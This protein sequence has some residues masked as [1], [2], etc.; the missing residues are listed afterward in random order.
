M[1][2]KEW[3]A[4]F[5]AT[6][7]RPAYAHT[8]VHQERLKGLT[9]W[10]A[11]HLIDVLPTLLHM[12]LLLFSL[13]PAV[14]LWT[15]DKGVA[16][17]EVIITGSTVIFYVGTTFLGA[18]YPSCPLVT[19]ISRYVQSFFDTIKRRID[20]NKSPDDIEKPSTIQYG[21]DNKLQALLWLAENAR[22]PLAGD[23]VRQALIGL[24]L[25]EFYEKSTE[26]VDTE[27]IK[28]AGNIIKISDLTVE[29]QMS[30]TN[31]IINLKRH[32]M[33]E[34]LYVAVL[35]RISEGRLRIPQE[36]DGYRGMELAQYANALPKMAYI[37]ES[38]SQSMRGAKG[39]GDAKIEKKPAPAMELAFGA[40]DSIWSEVDLKLS[41]DSYAAFP[42]AELQLIVSATLIHCSKSSSAT[43]ALGSTTQ[44][45]SRFGDQQNNASLAVP[46]STSGA[47]TL[48]DMELNAQNALNIPDNLLQIGARYSR[49]MS[50]VGYILSCHNKYGMHITTRALIGLLESIKSAAE[51]LE[52]N[53]QDQMSTCLPQPDMLHTLPNFTMVIT[54]HVAYEIHGVE[55]LAIGDEDGLL[56]GL[57]EI[58]SAAD[59]QDAPDFEF[60]AKR[61]LAIMGPVLLRQWATMMNA[62]SPDEF[63]SYMSEPGSIEQAHKCWSLLRDNRRDRTAHSRLLQLLIIATISVELASC[64][65]MIVLPNIAMVSLYRRAKTISGEAAWLDLAENPYFGYLISR[66][67]LNADRNYDKL[68]TEPLQL[69]TKLLLIEYKGK[70]MLDTDCLSPV[71]IPSMPRLTVFLPKDQREVLPVLDELQKM[72][73]LGKYLAPFTETSDGLDALCRVI[74][75]FDLAASPYAIRCIDCI[76]TMPTVYPTYSP[77]RLGFKGAATPGLLRAVRLIFPA[78]I[79]GKN[80]P[81]SRFEVVVRRVAN[82][83]MSSEGSNFVVEG[84]LDDS[85]TIYNALAPLTDWREYSSDTVFAYGRLAD[86]NTILYW[87]CG[88]YLMKR[89]LVK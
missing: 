16:I 69:F 76:I 7:L 37:L 54:P 20:T 3:L 44:D 51:R 2:A 79:A 55:P 64:P 13:G 34:N 84:C 85:T 12:S 25:D 74:D 40:L 89:T 78:L 57:V 77:N 60:A 71:S 73:S 18:V 61:A 68:S 39:S 9:R 10:C 11:L 32:R 30:E 31:R 59:I 6:R 80:S 22:N 67:A 36:P 46:T 26:P 83:L 5:K 8:V 35:A 1:L 14:Y 75:D 45:Q 65:Q 42:S 88:S 58:V 24:S 23:C 28:E 4:T 70:I 15:L 53:P 41:P 48:I 56:V 17:A 29:A 19:Q 62:R 50:F 43:H 21:N 63:N 72:W 52:L 47:G 49:A 82:V 66:L 33:V 86:P 81:A 87:D 38:R 27:T